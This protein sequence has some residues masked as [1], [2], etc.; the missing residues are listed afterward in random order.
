MK[1]KAKTEEE[2]REAKAPSP[3]NR[4]QLSEYIKS[5]VE[6]DHDYGTCVYAMSLAATAA[7]NYVARELGVTGFQASCADMDIL[8]RTRHM[9]KGFR[10]LNYDNLLYP[11][12]LTEDKFPSAGYLIAENKE[13]LAKWAKEKLEGADKFTSEAAIAHWEALAGQC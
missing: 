2:M 1:E 9:E 4:R 5:L 10:I 12:Y 3:K 11:Q 8:R 13:Q 6:R 7:F